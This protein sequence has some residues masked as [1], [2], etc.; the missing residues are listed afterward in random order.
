VIDV[1]TIGGLDA[2]S[3]RL[4]TL[5]DE[6]HAAPT[7]EG[8]ERVLL[9]GEREWHNRRQAIEDGIDLPADVR[10]KLA[11]VAKTCGIPELE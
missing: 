6:I 3:Q 11:D 10:A 5:V 9:P 8:V 1:A 4:Q 2:F 7:A